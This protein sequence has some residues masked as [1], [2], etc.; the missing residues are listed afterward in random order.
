[1]R[2]LDCV[3]GE[4]FEARTDAG[5]LDELRRHAEQEHPDW[6]EAELKRVL[7]ANAYDLAA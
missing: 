2:G 6:D 4:H 3:C 7:V 1:M 5:L